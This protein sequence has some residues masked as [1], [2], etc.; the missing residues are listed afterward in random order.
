MVVIDEVYHGIKDGEEGLLFTENG[1][2]HD[3]D[4][5]EESVTSCLLHL[6]LLVLETAQHWV[7]QLLQ[8]LV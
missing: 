7:E 1:L 3:F 5:V 6:H 4:D 2:L 8:I